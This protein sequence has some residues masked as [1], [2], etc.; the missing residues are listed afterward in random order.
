MFVE[1]A[2]R[3]AAVAGSSAAGRFRAHP[4]PRLH[5]QHA[6]GDAHRPGAERPAAQRDRQRRLAGP[7]PA[8]AGRAGAG[9]R[10]LQPGQGAW[11]RRCATWRWRGGGSGGST[12]PWPPTTWG[13]AIWPTVLGRLR[14]RCGGALR[15]AVLR[16]EP[17]PPRRRL[18]AAHRASATNPRCTCGGCSGADPGHA[19]VSDRSPGTGPAEHAADRV[20]PPPRRC[21]TPRTAPRPS[22]TRRRCRRPIVQRTLVPLPSDPL[23]LGLR[24]AGSI[25]AGAPTSAHRR[26]S[27]GGCVRR[28]SSCWRRWREG[29]GRWPEGTP[30]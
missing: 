29:C 25:G 12:W 24:Y 5:R 10:P 19:P 17:G 11:P 14:R 1:S 16:R 6:A 18:P 8:A 3:P 23:R 4:D 22:R 9:R 28:R 30:P 15:P 13:S 20:S 7:V 21:S 26:R 27:T 2:G